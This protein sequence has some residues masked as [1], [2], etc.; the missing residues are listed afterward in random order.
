MDLWPF[1]TA[2]FSRALHYLSDSGKATSAH[3]ETHRGV[4]DS[5]S[6]E[7]ADVQLYST[8]N[9]TNYLDTGRRDCVRCAGLCP[10]VV[11]QPL[12]GSFN[13]IARPLSGASLT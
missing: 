7:C 8:L 5:F 9:T 1:C 2:V 6:R 10:V 13:V 11:S 3:S 4:I 12:T